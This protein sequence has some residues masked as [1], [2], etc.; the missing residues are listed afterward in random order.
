MATKQMN[1]SWRRVRN[2]IREIW[3][4]TDLGTD[5]ELKKTRGSMRKMINLIHD[6]TGE[7]RAEI[8]NK[9]GAIV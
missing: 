3:S 7:P 5:K 6:R 9:I 8:F 1:E 2:R 4:D